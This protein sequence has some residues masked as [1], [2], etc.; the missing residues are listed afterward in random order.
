M[1]PRSAFKA[2]TNPTGVAPPKNQTRYRWQDMAFGGVDLQD[3]SKGHVYQL[4]T[5]KYS[6]MTGS[7]VLTSNDGKVR[8]IFTLHGIDEIALAFDVNC[9]WVLAYRLTDRRA[10]VSYWH[11]AILGRIVEF[12]GRCTSLMMTTDDARGM[13][14]GVSD[15][16]VSCVRPDRNLIVYGQREKYRKAHN[17]GVSVPDD[18]EL[19]NFGMGNNGRLQWVTVNQKI[20]ALP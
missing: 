16:L 12:L 18:Q 1:I 11:D 19:A 13:P 6:P 15:I 10:F 8:P 2:D 5:A 3:N 9:N 4:W 7:V 20:K 17:M 14:I